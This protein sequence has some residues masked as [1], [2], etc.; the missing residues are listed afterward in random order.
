MKLWKGLYFGV[1]MADKRPVQQELAVNVALLLEDI[2]REKQIM[3][4]DCFWET[5][6]AAWEN[7]DK[8]RI[9]KYLL[10]IRIVVA[11]SF[12]VMRVAGWPAAEM[13][14]LGHVFTRAMPIHARDGPNAPS[15]G[16]LLQFTRIVWEE[17]RHEM[18]AGA[19]PKK[20]ILSFLE[21]FCIIAEGSAIDSLV[22]HIHEHILLKAP[23][24]FLDSL[25][26]RVLAGAAKP[27]SR[28]K[29]REALYET[30]DALEKI[31]RSAPPKGAKPL[32]LLCSSPKGK[33]PKGKSPKFPASLPP[34]ELPPMSKPLATEPGK[35]KKR[36]K[37]K[38][39]LS[40]GVSPLLLPE[41][42]LPVTASHLTGEV[43]KGKKKKK[44]AGSPTVQAEAAPVEEPKKKR[45]L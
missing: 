14:S 9:G 1:W 35:K 26:P 22:R 18:E 15:L 43:G 16:L 17:L 11:E 8:H 39:V 28:K 6:Q 33:S 7:L 13:S 32:Q 24:E 30:A 20:A 40:G 38:K 10:F 29:N 36:K 23:H 21:P 5:M 2:P 25:T 12:K 4:M 27:D 31:A 41:A 42:M 45:R 19:T 44:R 3:W 37:V 34:L